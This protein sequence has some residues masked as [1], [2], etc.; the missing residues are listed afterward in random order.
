MKFLDILNLKYIQQYKHVIFLNPKWRPPS[1]WA[2]HI[3]FAFFLTSLIKPKKFVEL[4][5][6]SGASYFAFC[7]AI[8]KI[9]QSI[10]FKTECY[11]VDTWEGDKHAGRYSEDVY[12]VVE[13][14][15]SY[16]KDFSTLLRMTFEQALLLEELEDIDL[17]HIDG[18]HTYEAVSS[19]FNNW[20][21]KMSE[22]GVILF[23]DT[24]EK[25]EDFGVYKF[26][27]E[28]SRKYPSFEFKHGHGLGVLLVGK[29]V[30]KNIL[31][32]QSDKN[33]KY[34]EHFFK[35]IGAAL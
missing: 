21:P 4:G 26:W 34:Y 3:P 24:Y 8:S 13:G 32:F 10:D 2:S 14:A 31:S 9:K 5:T 28:V 35:V 27:D 19:D 20:L 30:D 11:A 7:E 6:F 18:L 22:K 29:N 16:Y 17:L 23:H 25:R 15:N 1:A 33:L 12:K